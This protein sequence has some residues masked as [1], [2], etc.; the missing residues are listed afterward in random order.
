MAHSA[1]ATARP[2]PLT[3]W[4]DLSSRSAAARWSS[5]WRR[6]LAPE[7]ER[8]RPV[9]RRRTGQ[10]LVGRAGHPGTG[11]A[12]QHDEVALVAEL[13]ANEHV[14]VVDEPQHADLGGGRDPTEWRFVVQAD[15]AAGDRDAQRAAGVAHAA[16]RLAELPERL[17]VAWDRRS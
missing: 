10:A 12:E 13:R 5:F 7:V 8:R 2:P 14:D 16:D 4:A 6:R 17:G 15:V 11:L 9:V 3:S 1:M